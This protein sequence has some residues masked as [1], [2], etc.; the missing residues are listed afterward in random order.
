[1]IQWLRPNAVPWVQQDTGTWSWQYRRI[2]RIILEGQVFR[3]G[4]VGQLAEQYP[5]RGKYQESRKNADTAVT[6]L[7]EKEPATPLRGEAFGSSSDDA[8]A[9]V[10][11]FPPPGHSSWS[12]PRLWLACK[13][14]LLDRFT[15]AHDSGVREKVTHK[16]FY[17]FELILIYLLACGSTP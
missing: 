3:S 5:Q 7:P 6:A 15:P 10:F 4:S 1:L 13:L 14:W 16:I 17:H 9:V 2:Q 12:I 11:L 8:G